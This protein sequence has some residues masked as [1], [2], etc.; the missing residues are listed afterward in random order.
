MMKTSFFCILSGSLFFAQ[1]AMTYDSPNYSI[2]VPEGW[3]STN[4]SEIINIFLPMRSEPL[5]F[6][7][8][9]I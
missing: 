7:N 4:D 2:N 3:K 6:Q 5:P 9:M 1:K 8:I